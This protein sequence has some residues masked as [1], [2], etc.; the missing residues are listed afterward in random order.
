MNELNKISV[1][2][3]VEDTDIKLGTLVY[4]NRKIF[5]KLDKDY[6][7]HFN[8][9]SDDRLLLSPFRLKHSSEIQTTK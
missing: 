9:F 6:Q 2:L 1:F 3:N 7:R 4:Q 5:F 8:S